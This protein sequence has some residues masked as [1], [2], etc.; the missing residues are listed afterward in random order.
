MIPAALFWIMTPRD[1]I[2]PDR[3]LGLPCKKLA[4]LMLYACFLAHR[5]IVNG[6][7]FFPETRFWGAIFF[8]NVPFIFPCP[9][10]YSSNISQE[11]APHRR[12]RRHRSPTHHLLRRVTL[13]RAL[14][15][16]HAAGDFTEWSR[17]QIWFWKRLDDVRRAPNSVAD[18]RILKRHQTFQK[19][20]RWV[21]WS[22]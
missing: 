16:S 8:Q 21:L 3:S 10:I 14:E 9:T 6:D 4:M 11:K 12:R 2:G 20:V 19:W 18:F 15:I 13:S 5:S 7:L 17:D 1:I 22:I